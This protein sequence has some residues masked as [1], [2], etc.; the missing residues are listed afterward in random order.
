MDLL[1]HDSVR[2][3]AHGIRSRNSVFL[4]R[5]YAMIVNSPGTITTIL[6]DALSSLVFSWDVA[7]AAPAAVPENLTGCPKR[8]P[9][10]Q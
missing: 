6:P 9:Y 1:Y 7:D 3:S 10:L 5:Y 8:L 4:F 2:V